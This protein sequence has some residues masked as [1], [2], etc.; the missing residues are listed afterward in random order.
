MKILAIGAHPDD[1]E[2]FMFGL[3]SV[4]ANRGD[5]IGLIIAT[6]GAAGS[7]L[8]NKSL[9]N[10]R[11]IETRK[12]LKDLGD[13]NLLGIPDGHLAETVNAKKIISNAIEYENPDL[14]ITHAPEDYHPDHR[15]LSLFVEDIAG[16]KCPV[17][18]S[19]TLM[20]VNFNPEFYID[21]TMFF[22]AKANAIMCHKTQVPERFVS[23]T[24]LMN[25]FRAAQCNAPDFNY[26]EAYRVNNRFPFSDIRSLIPEPP[27]LK[28][29]YQNN[30]NALI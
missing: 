20:G 4:Y 26:A 14:I 12:A 15:A 23:A 8:S 30:S 24:K 17:I 9:S 29:F 10:I 1:I 25:R 27:P 2:I 7:V 13:P 3:L 16:F 19:D 6:D 21:I 11:E 18:F 5:Q 28:P 22:E